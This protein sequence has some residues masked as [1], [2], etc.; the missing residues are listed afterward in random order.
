MARKCSPKVEAPVIEAPVEAPA[1]RFKSAS[2][3]TDVFVNTM[4]DVV[5]QGG[6]VA[7]V[8]TKLDRPAQYVSQ[9]AALL[10]KAGVPLPKFR[11]P[12]RAK[13]NLDSLIE[14]VKGRLEKMGQ[15]E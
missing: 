2:I 12:G 10:R 11:R 14:S 7:D 5:E 8:A 9:R 3:P 1:K 6:N 15:A 13:A 4:L